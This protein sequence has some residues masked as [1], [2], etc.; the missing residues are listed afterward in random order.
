MIHLSNYCSFRSAPLHKN[1]LNLQTLMLLSGTF[2]F[3]Q[4]FY[5]KFWTARIMECHHVS[6]IRT[7]IKCNLFILILAHAISSR[8]SFLHLACTPVFTVHFFSK[9]LHCMLGSETP[10]QQLGVE[11]LLCWHIIIGD[12]LLEV[13]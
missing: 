13:F 12:N 11:I 1:M 10:F 2:G 5:P 6:H 9:I 7:G 8:S 3:L 4:G